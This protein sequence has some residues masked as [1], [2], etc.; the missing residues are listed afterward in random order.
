M[1]CVL[2]AILT[3]L[4]TVAAA[5]VARPNAQLTKIDIELQEKLSS[6]PGSLPVFVLLTAQSGLD[7][8][9]WRQSPHLSKSQWWEKVVADLKRLAESEQRELV[10]EAKAGGHTLV[11]DRHFWIV[12]GFSLR[13]DPPAIRWLADSDRVAQIF[14]RW[15][16]P[17]D[18]IRKEGRFTRAFEQPSPRPITVDEVTQQK[19]PPSWN[20]ARIQA[21]LVWSRLGLI[22]RGVVLAILDSGV[23]YRHPDFAHHLWRNDGEI[24]GNGRDD[25]GNG[26][27]DD[28]YGYNF[29]NDNGNVDDDFFHG[30]SSAGIMVGDG[31]SGMLTGVAPGAQLMILRMY[32]QMTR[33]T[34]V[35]LW[36]AYQ[37]DAWEAMQYAVQEKADVINMSFAWEPAEYPLHAV[38]R[39]ACTNVVAAGVT[40]VAG[41]G[42]FRGFYHVPDQIRPPASVPAVLATGGTL[43]DDA[44]SPLSSRG[45][46]VWSR[47]PPFVDYPSPAGLFKPEVSAPFGNFPVIPFRGRGYQ[48]LSGQAGSSLTSPHVV[49]VIALMLEASPELRPDEI[50]DRLVNTSRDVGEIGP[51]PYAGAGLVQAYD[52]IMQDI[53]RLNLRGVRFRSPQPLPAGLSP[54]SSLTATIH[55]SRGQSKQVPARIR[56]TSSDARVVIERPEVDVARLDDATELSFPIH[57]GKDLPVGRVIRLS[58]ETA[59][60]VARSQ[61]EVE[62]PTYGSDTLL[63]D[64]DGGGEQ[65]KAWRES[66]ERLGVAHDL[67]SV[68][69]QGAAARPP[70]R[71]YRTVIWLKGEEVTSTFTPTQRAEIA[72]Y[73]RRGG[74]LIVS[75]QNV[76]SDLA[77]DTWLAEVF[78]TRFVNSRGRTTRLKGAPGSPL[79]DFNAPYG[80]NSLPDAIAAVGS[81]RVVLP[82]DEP[83]GAGLAVAT[84]HTWFLSLELADVNGDAAR[85]RL[86][87]AMQ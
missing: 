85:D 43:E 48:V 9:S 19:Q 55:L 72:M 60:S 67:F 15:E 51:D 11:V 52:A 17:A 53:P 34:N 63:V 22:G 45:P 4:A 66:L 77:H 87:R 69:K 62:L 81:G 61:L 57:L 24:A 28:I 12:N 80:S 39:Y 41:S 44:I 13:L 5:V 65:Q 25:D 3:A 29:A 74:R 84:D 49:G 35:E 82:I 20:L 68:W 10:L 86:V 73:V 76:A 27:V 78:G 6:T 33:Y 16:K 26:Y 2:V 64:D 36:R 37:Y 56:L 31:R 47:Y 83:A 71:N 38:W 54:G 50:R 18:I 40:M 42:N 75:G 30:T 59:F 70:L 21:D 7:E 32:D 58:L 23:N 14:Y 46:V 79:D 8:T 1:T